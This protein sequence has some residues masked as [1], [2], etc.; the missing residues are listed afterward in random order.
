MFNSLFFFM[1]LEMDIVDKII[2][3]SIVIRFLMIRIFSIVLVNC[4]ECIFS[5]VNVCMIMVVEVMDKILLRK[6]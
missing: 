1:L 2:S 5:F 4:L 6:R 3:K